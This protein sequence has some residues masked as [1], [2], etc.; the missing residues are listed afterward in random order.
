MIKN[1]IG[2]CSALGAYATIKPRDMA[3]DF[4]NVN[5]VVGDAFDQ[6]SFSDFESKYLVL[7][8]YPFDFTYVCPTELIAFSEAV[9]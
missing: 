2:F 7:V 8:F 4:K 1:L 6:I 9:P 5:A 3:P